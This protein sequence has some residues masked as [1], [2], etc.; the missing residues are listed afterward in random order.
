MSGLRTI[1]EDAL[2]DNGVQPNT[3]AMHSWRCYDPERFPGYCSCVP[4]LVDDLM[5]RIEARYQLFDL[6]G[7]DQ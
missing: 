5:E 4:Q 6:A 7:D 2:R 3:D 1:I